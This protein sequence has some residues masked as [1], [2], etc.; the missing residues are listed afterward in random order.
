MKK[1]VTF[2][3]AVASFAVLTPTASQ[4]RDFHG[5]SSRSFSHNC[6]SCR[7][8]VYRERA[9]TGYDRHGHPVYG[10]RTIGHSCR[11]SYGSGH[12]HGG[13]SSGHGSNHGSGGHFSLPGFHFDFGGRGRH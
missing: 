6:G 1:L 12:G 9:V 10:Y 2:L 8:P 11:P 5:S 7:T 3:A 4:A 13:H